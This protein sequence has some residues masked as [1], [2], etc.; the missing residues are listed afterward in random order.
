MNKINTIMAENVFVADC[1]GTQSRNEVLEFMNYDLGNTFAD[2]LNVDEK[3]IKE[4]ETKKAEILEAINYLEER[5]AKIDAIA[6]PAV[7]ESEEMTN[8][9]EAINDEISTLKESYANVQQ[10]LRDFT[11]IS[12]G[13]GANVNDEVEHLKKKQE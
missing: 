7:R 11:T 2:L 12:E 3:Q 9:Y 5:K 10:E 13:V 6:N 1:N 8:I 4:L